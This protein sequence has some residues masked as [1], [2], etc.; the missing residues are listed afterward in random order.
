MGGNVFVLGNADVLR[1]LG[2]NTVIKVILQICV[3]AVKFWFL[4][5]VF[6]FALLTLHLM[7]KWKSICACY[8]FSVLPNSIVHH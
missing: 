8:P 1:D 6:M 3:L 2:G 7:N 5:F 4:R